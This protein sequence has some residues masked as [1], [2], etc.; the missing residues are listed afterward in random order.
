MLVVAASQTRKCI[1]HLCVEKMYSRFAPCSRIIMRTF[2]EV[3]PHRSGFILNLLWM[4]ARMSERKWSALLRRRCADVCLFL[5]RTICIYKSAEGLRN[6]SFDDRLWRLTFF[7]ARFRSLFYLLV[8]WYLICISNGSTKRVIII[9]WLAL[10]V[11]H[12]HTKK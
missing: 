3:T 6:L 5:F 7:Y 10:P 9:L 11:T 12:T 4:A 1:I 8:I 2:C